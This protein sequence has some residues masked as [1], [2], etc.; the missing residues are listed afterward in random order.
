MFRFLT[1]PIDQY[2]TNISQ[3]FSFKIDSWSV[4]FVLNVTTICHCKCNVTNTT[5]SFK[6]IFKL[7]HTARYYL[8]N[9]NNHTTSEARTEINTG[10]P[11]QRGLSHTA[12]NA[13]VTAPEARTPHVIGQIAGVRLSDWLTTLSLDVPCSWYSPESEGACDRRLP[14]FMLLRSLIVGFWEQLSLRERSA[15]R[16]VHKEGCGNVCRLLPVIFLLS[17]W[18]GFY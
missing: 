14:W 11:K 3:L 15:W 13:L 16:Y 9:N 2:S 1:M 8:K 18:A 12:G 10:R 7:F 17:V 5:L 6:Q 4:S